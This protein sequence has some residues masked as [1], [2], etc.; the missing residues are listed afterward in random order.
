M[1]QS[2]LEEALA[3]ITGQTGPRDVAATVDPSK[4]VCCFFV[5]AIAS[6]SNAPSLLRLTSIKLHLIIPRKSF[7]ATLSIVIMS[8]ALMVKKKKTVKKTQTISI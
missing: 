4:M 6:H 7:L 5:Y 1:N 3:L 2:D 8:K